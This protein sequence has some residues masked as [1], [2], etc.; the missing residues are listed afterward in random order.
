MT[1]QPTGRLRGNDLVLSRRFRASIEDV[2]TSITASSS[3]ARWFGGWEGTPGVGNEIRVQM[4]FEDGQPWITKKIEVCEAPDRLV[5]S[6]VGSAFASRLELSL[7]AIGDGCELELIHHAIDRARVGEVGPGWE[8]YLDALV[9]SRA[10]QPRLAFDAY[11]PAQ[12]AYF[13]GLTQA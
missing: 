4:A 7:K 10:D 6:S 9:A 5:L 11:Y 2:W 1:P 8:Y 3:T 12:K 13:L